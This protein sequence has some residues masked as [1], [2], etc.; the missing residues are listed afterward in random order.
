MKI[1][2]ITVVFNNKETIRRAIESVLSQN[3]SNIEYLIIDGASTDGTIDIINNYKNK[4]NKFISEKDEGIYDAMNK[5]IELATGD[6]VGILNSDDSYIDEN[7]VSEIAKTFEKYNPDSVFADVIMVK[8]HDQKAIVRYYSAKKFK[9][10]HFRFGHMPGHATF[11]A[12]REL[13]DKLGK[14]DTKYKISADFDLLLRF[15]FVNRISYKYIPKVLVRM[16]LG[17]VSTQG[18]SSIKQMNLEL[19]HSLRKN[20]VKS[21]IIM[22]YMKYFVKIFQFALR[23]KS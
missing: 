22:I 23:P 1:S 4:I 17:G 3:Y 7:S 9:L 6:V 10:W 15:L 2:I 18:L 21:N 14:Y 20:R 16:S 8:E 13:F 19:K 11:F 12:K 5:G